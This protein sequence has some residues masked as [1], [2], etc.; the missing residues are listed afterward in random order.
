MSHT[1]YPPA[2]PLPRL[3]W[4]SLLL[5]EDSQGTR[6]AISRR[7]DSL[8]KPIRG[9]VPSPDEIVQKCDDLLESTNCYK[10]LKTTIQTTLV[11]LIHASI[12]TGQIGWLDN[13]S[14]HYRLRLLDVDPRYT[15]KEDALQLQHE[16]YSST[17]EKL[18]MIIA[19]ER[20]R[21]STFMGQP[22]EPLT[23]NEPTA[24]MSKLGDLCK[25]SGSAMMRKLFYIVTAYTVPSNCNHA[26]SPNRC[27]DT[28]C[29][30]IDCQLHRT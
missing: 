9:H 24:C 11:L 28:E 3:K 16:I 12:K 30:H 13:P 10:D 19:S 17:I 8:E 2:K 29:S 21:D 5:R 4:S 1:Y 22:F 27:E 18:K 26:G 6:A 20:L 25:S 15:L 7:L 14:L 23:H